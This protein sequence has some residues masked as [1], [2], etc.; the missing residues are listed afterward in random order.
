MYSLLPKIQMQL[1]ICNNKLRFVFIMA[2][3]AS[4]NTKYPTRF[5][6]FDIKL[7]GSD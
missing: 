2:L 5:Y 1:Y 4:I 6:F 3:F 7:L